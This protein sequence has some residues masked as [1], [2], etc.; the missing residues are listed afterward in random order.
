MAELM[1]KVWGQYPVSYRREETPSVRL[2]CFFNALPPWGRVQRTVWSVG[3]SLLRACGIPS[4][5]GRVEFDRVRSEDWAESW[6]KHFHPLRIGAELLIKPS[7]SR[8]RSG[9]RAVVVLDPGLSFGTG[10]HP[11][12]AFCLRQIVAAKRKAEAPSLFDIGTGSGILAIAAA[13]LGYQRVAGIDFDSEAIRIARA[14][15]SQNGVRIP[16]KQR[17]I[18]DSSVRPR[19]HFDVICANLEYPLIISHA[20][21]IIAGL[22]PRG[23]LVL[24]GILTSQFGSVLKRYVQAGFSLVAEEKNAE[25][26][27]GAFQRE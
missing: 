20:E 3:L 4:G 5:P 15:A 23:L 19:P 10:Q 27:S 24:A 1:E 6:K 17:D 18:T 9:H 11:T 12:T 7:W 21:R 13:K 14:N 8:T 22:R 25:W 26:R 2:T 16:F